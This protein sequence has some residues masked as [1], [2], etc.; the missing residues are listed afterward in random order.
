[1]IIQCIGIRLSGRKHPIVG[2][3][4]FI[5]ARQ[6]LQ[7]TGTNGEDIKRVWDDRERAV[8]GIEGILHAAERHQRTAAV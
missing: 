8:A 3:E 5:I 7:S 1:M 2:R 6:S 4:R